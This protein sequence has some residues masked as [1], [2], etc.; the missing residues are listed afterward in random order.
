M[1]IQGMTFDEF[2]FKFKAGYITNIDSDLVNE[3]IAY[4]ED[5]S[6]VD[7]MQE[8]LDEADEKIE[9]LEDTITDLENDLSRLNDEMIH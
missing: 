1:Q 7:K 3:L 9:E 6:D 5:T 4:A 8:L 2:V